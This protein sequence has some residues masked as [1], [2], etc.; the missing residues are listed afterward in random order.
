MTTRLSGLQ[1]SEEVNSQRPDWWL[2][3]WRQEYLYVVAQHI[4]SRFF[5]GVWG[6]GE[7][8]TAKE[9]LLT[10]FE[11]SFGDSRVEYVVFAMINSGMRGARDQVRFGRAMYTWRG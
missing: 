3:R 5:L 10:N 7:L 9:E 6:V 1:V 2:Q 8:G 11:F 4:L